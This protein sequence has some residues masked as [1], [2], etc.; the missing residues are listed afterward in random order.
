MR[1]WRS[2]I[3]F[4]LVV[5][6]AGFA[7]AIYCLAPAPDSTHR[8]GQKSAFLDTLR[9]EDFAQSFNS[10]MHKC[11]NFAKDAAGRAGKCVKQKLDERKAE[12]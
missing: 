2:K 11:F 9:S 5:Y 8:T 3:V 10:G 1:G 6:F 4:L 7:T 12:S